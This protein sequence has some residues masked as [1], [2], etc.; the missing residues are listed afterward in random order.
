MKTGKVPGQY[1]VNDQRC[2][3]KYVEIWRLYG[4]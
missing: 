4:V 2:L 1:L 3:N